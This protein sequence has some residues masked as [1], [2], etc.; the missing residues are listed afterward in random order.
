MSPTV[1]IAGATGN[2]GVAVVETLSKLQAANT[3]PILSNRRIVAHSWSADSRIAQH[4][5]SLSGVSVAEKLWVDITPEWPV[6]NQVARAFIAAQALPTHFV[7]ESA[8]LVAA[9]RVGVRYVVRISTT[10]ANVRPDCQA[11]YSRPHWA[12]EALLAA[13]KF[14]G[15]QWTSLQPNLFSAFYFASAAEFVQGYRRIGKQEPSG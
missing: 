7:E 6:D 2:T 8:F 9:L 4:L 11:F 15:M 12:L 13:P 5:A 3:D 10:V 14:A 1:L